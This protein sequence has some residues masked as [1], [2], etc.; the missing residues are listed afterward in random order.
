LTELLVSQEST[1]LSSN[2]SNW[3]EET[4]A[5]INEHLCED[6]TLEDLAARAALKEVCFN[7]GF[8]SEAAFCTTFKKW[9]T[10]T[11]S[12]YRNQVKI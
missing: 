9:E 8:A 1:S 5:Y 12:A 6:L 11:P 10:I 3:I 7:S 2:T 4:T